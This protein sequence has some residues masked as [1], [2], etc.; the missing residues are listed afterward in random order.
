MKSF[1]SS[2]V[3]APKIL[4]PD[5]G[6][7]YFFGYYDLP[8]TDLEGRHLCHRVP[9][10]DR[11]QEA[12]DVA[13]LGY[14]K[15][16]AFTSFATTTAWNFQQGA[17]LQFYSSKSDTVCYNF[18]QNGRFCTVIHDLRSGE[19]QYTDRAA[20]TI[21]EDGR[22]GLGVNFGRIFAFR[23]GYGY[24]DFPDK[25]AE[26]N[27]PKDDGVFLID[28]E[29]GC[30]KLLVSYAQ[31]APISGFDPSKKILVNHINFSPDCNHYV[32]LVRDFPTPE[33][34]G[35]STSLM[36]GDRSGKLRTVLANTVVSHYRWVN[37]RELVVYCSVNGRKGV[38]CM[39]MESDVQAAYSIPYMQTAQNQDI[40]C[41]LVPNGKY[42]IGDGYPMDGYRYVVAY[43]RE[44]GISK[45]L[46]GVATVVP[47]VI[48][49]R[50]DLHVRFSADG[51]W[52]TY[53][54]TEN[55][56]RQIA[57]ISTD[58]LSF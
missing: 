51:R 11:M 26:V 28:M 41:N 19:K 5:D 36:L 27:A 39:D 7:H 54:T 46:F 30:S 38:Y 4:T 2:Y 31:M 47:P 35:W 49:I 17:L 50:C 22:W 43:N 16:E 20:A 14:V 21:S 10:M 18:V 9:F 56:R 40:H 32:M 33:K 57:A 23:P 13:E 24:A 8:A 55:A 42:V 44:N 34:K 15:E 3:Q 12:D 6:Y 48:D 1:I 45:T 52:I 53:D 58:V 25:N 37:A 29:T